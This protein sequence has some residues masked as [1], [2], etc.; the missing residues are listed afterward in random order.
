MATQSIKDA[1]LVSYETFLQSNKDVN[2]AIDAKDY[3]GLYPKIGLEAGYTEAIINS[4]FKYS[5]GKDASMSFS[6]IDRDAKQIL[7]Y[8]TTTP[9]GMRSVFKAYRYTYNESFIFVPDPISLTFL[10]GNERV[11]SLYNIG[12]NFAL[13]GIC[14]TDMPKRTTRIVL[15]KTD[16]SSMWSDWT[17]AYDVTSL[18]TAGSL[19]PTPNIALVQQNGQDYILRITGI[20]TTKLDIFNSSLQLLRSLTVFNEATDMD[21]T[22]RTSQGRT[23]VTDHIFLYYGNGSMP[24]FTWNPATES[25]HFRFTGWQTVKYTNGS[26][27]GHGFSMSVAWKIPFSWISAGSGATSN[28][29]PIKSNGFR[30][31]TYID[32]TW[33]TDTGG[34]SEADSGA[35]IATVTD[36]Y[37]GDIHHTHR[38]TWDAWQGGLIRIVGYLAGSPMLT[39]ASN[40]DTRLKNS[41]SVVIPDGSPYAKGFNANSSIIIGSYLYTH[42]ISGSRNDASVRVNFSTTVFQDVVSAKDTLYLDP[43]SIVK[44]PFK[45]SPA[46]ET[47]LFASRFNTFVVGG[48]GRRILCTPGSKLLELSLVG[49]VPTWTTLNTVFPAIPVQVQGTTVI[50]SDVYVWNGNTSTPVFYACIKTPTY[51]QMIKHSA[52]SWALHGAAVGVDAI[53]DGNNR[54]GD[55]AYEAYFNRCNTLLT[56]SGKLLFSFRLP[57]PG[58]SVPLAVVV[59][60][61]AGT[62]TTN[63]VINLFAGKPPV[64]SIMYNYAE[65]HTHGTTAYGFSEVFGYYALVAPLNFTSFRIISSKD[66][67]GTGATITETQWLNNTATRHE[68]VVSASSSVGL[69][70]YLSEYPIFIGGY[71]TKIPQTTISL[72]PNTTNYIFAT[73]GT[74]ARDDVQ[75]SVSSRKFTDTFSRVCIAKVVTSV[76]KV[77]STSTYSVDGMGL[78][79]QTGKA[80]YVLATNGK[81][82]YWKAP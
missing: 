68:I 65:V 24:G 16:G 6:M 31:R 40:I 74:S 14:S 2:A 5:I 30:Y 47:G 46:T 57:V 39:Y 34:M 63:N 77:L 29:I 17:F 73:K 55:T 20:Q 54:R 3:L 80:G 1:N 64:A 25:L 52:G 33:N 48:V 19:Y 36:E 50:D 56:E 72:L 22:D 27:I 12:T 26:T 21:F 70:A 44:D 43:T 11:D 78:P 81:N 82:A 58:D 4:D 53:N 8:H 13:V 45:G 28:L 49:N 60:T 69:L 59:D 66:I 71:F 32:S 35:S 10:A 61:V 76:D 67:R 75:I 62:S 79:D 23:G 9:T 38:G 51:Y 15:V 18:I 42:G 37:S 7:F 41:Y